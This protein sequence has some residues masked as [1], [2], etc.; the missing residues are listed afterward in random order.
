MWWWI[1]AVIFVLLFY[2][3][4]ALFF[5]LESF[6]NSSVY[7]ICMSPSRSSSHCWIRCPAALM[8]LVSW[9]FICR[10]FLLPICVK[11]FPKFVPL[12]LLWPRLCFSLFSALIYCWSFQWHLIKV[13]FCF[14]LITLHLYVACCIVTA[15]CEC[16]M[17]IFRILLIFVDI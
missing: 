1:R 11:V 15:A 17:V 5:K 13:V 6:H 4:P 3:F 8:Y 2:L 12:W 16:F 9:L 7:D 14:Y 10:L